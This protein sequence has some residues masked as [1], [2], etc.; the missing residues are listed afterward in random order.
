MHY[1]ANT[2]NSEVESRMNV[3]DHR[4][5]EHLIKPCFIAEEKYAFHNLKESLNDVY[6]VLTT[7]KKLPAQRY[8]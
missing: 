7:C 2:E 3:I 4:C 1:T 8:A 5:S 6:I